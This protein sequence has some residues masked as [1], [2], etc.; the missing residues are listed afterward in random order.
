MTLESWVK[1]S[2]LERQASD[3]EEIG[4]LL[5]RVVLI[6]GALALEPQA[7]VPSCNWS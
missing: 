6:Y 4:R 3:A 7:R 5:V 2:W 1:N